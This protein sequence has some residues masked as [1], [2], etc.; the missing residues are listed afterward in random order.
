M[1]APLIVGGSAVGVLEVGRRGTPARSARRPAPAHRRRPRGRRHRARA[2]RGRSAR[3]GRRRAAYRRRRRRGGHR[4]PRDAS[5]TRAFA[6]MVGATPEALRG[7]R[8]TEFLA[9]AQDIA[10]LT[11][12]MRQP[13]LPGRGAADHEARASR[14]RCWSASPRSR[15]EGGARRAHRRLPRHQ[16]RARAAVPRDP[17]AE[18]PHAR[19]AGGRRRAQHQQPPHARA[20]V[21]RDAARAA[22]RP[23]R[24]WIT[25]SSS[26]RSP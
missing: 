22:R 11:E 13:T 17:R 23:A 1:V 6:E 7:R 20:R 12:R 21:D 16:P 24:R 14:A 3:A 2:A 15:R 25:A 8:W 4:G 10:A 5:P 19:L 18:V 9:G 26:T